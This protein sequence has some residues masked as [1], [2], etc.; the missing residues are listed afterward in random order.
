MAKAITAAD[1]QTEVLIILKANLD[2]GVISQIDYDA[3]VAAI[4]LGVRGE[5][6]RQTIFIRGN[7]KF[8]PSWAT[9]ITMTSSSYG[10]C[11]AYTTHDI[12]GLTLAQVQT[13]VA[14]F[15]KSDTY[16]SSFEVTFRAYDR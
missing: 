1:A 12:T 11:N 9:E 14:D 2:T 16:M 15:I 7:V 3:A 8:V 10:R 6:K 5:T 4:A 13:L